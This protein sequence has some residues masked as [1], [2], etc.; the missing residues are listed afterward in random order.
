M[1][2]TKL[3]TVAS[4]RILL[5]EDDPDLRVTTRLVLEQHGHE[6]AVAVDGAEALA[7][8]RTSPPDLVIA[9]IV[10]PKLDGLTLT[11]RLREDSNIPI[12]MLTARDLSHDEIAGLEAGADDYITKPFDGDVL[13]SRIRAV[14]RRGGGSLAAEPRRVGSLVVDFTRLTA[15]YDGNPVEL[16]ATEFRILD[17]LMERPGAVL[18]RRQLL[19]A[20]WG[21][22]AWAE[23]RIVDVNIHRL[24]SKL[25]SEV[26]TTVRGAGYRMGP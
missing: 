7:M 26:I 20:A 5:A 13:D 22:E 1:L 12:I 15:E 10:M 9:D 6:V 24:R 2:A 8:I 18:S 16:S 3:K 21:D 11:R 19:R 25:A 4:I 23:E 17:A 14:L